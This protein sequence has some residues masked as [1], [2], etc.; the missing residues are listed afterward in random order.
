[1]NNHKD[2]FFTFPITLLS[3]FMTNTEGVCD[4]ILY[5][6]A[7]E[8]YLKFNNIEETKTFF[9]VKFGDEKHAMEQGK[10]LSQSTNRK[11]P[12]T[13]CSVNMYWSYRNENDE[14][15][16]A[17][18]LAFLAIKSIVG[19]KAYYK[20]SQVRIFKRMAG[21]TDAFSD[22]LPDD[23]APWCERYKFNRIKDELQE[24]FGVTIYA[25]HSRG[26]YVS[27]KLDL[28]KLIEAAERNK[29]S[30]RS[31]KKKHMTEEAYRKAIAVVNSEAP[32]LST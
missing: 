24:S 23:I 19:E 29:L 20:T 28:Q 12:W 10:V 21:M 8:H 11:V 15:S 2:R 9:T 17:T 26:I 16:K 32:K 3:G 30:Y 6:C 22:Q 18:F 7:Y 31:A 14:L 4:K 13:S 5:F 25:N 27:T 1:M